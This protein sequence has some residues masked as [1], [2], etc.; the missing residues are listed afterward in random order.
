MPLSACTRPR[1]T[2][3]PGAKS[4]TE[5]E[6]TV[7]ALSVLSSTSVDSAISVFSGMLVPS[8]QTRIPLTVFV[9]IVSQPFLEANSDS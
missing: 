5:I 8:E 6:L 2:V 7:Y 4:P 1:V 9:A 3:F